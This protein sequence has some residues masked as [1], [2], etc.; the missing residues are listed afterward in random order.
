MDITGLQKSYHKHGLTLTELSEGVFSLSNNKALESI[1]HVKEVV[2]LLGLHKDF[3]MS[4]LN[5]NLEEKYLEY[6]EKWVSELREYYRDPQN[7]AGFMGGPDGVFILE[8]KVLARYMILEILPDDTAEVSMEY[9]RDF[10]SNN[11]LIPTEYNV[12]EGQSRGINDL[13]K[14]VVSNDLFDLFELVP[15]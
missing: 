9:T 8:A 5:R 12:K 14:L 7:E 2:N 15:E 13:R 3:E 4:K 11:P 10:I 1:L 6:I